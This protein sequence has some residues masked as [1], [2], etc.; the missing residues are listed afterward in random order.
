MSIRE[1][2]ESNKAQSLRDKV[3]EQLPRTEEAWM[4][5][6]WLI[7]RKPE[8]GHLIDKNTSIR[9][10]KSAGDIKIQVPDITV[11]YTFN[12]SQVNIRNLRF[13]YDN[14]VLNYADTSRE[15]VHAN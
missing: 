2:I 3:T 7:A 13:E 6:T 11:I 15:T 12:D 1:I 8:I 4:G 14:K 5:I 10:Y 9:L